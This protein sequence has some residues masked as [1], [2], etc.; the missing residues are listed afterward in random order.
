M[1]AAQSRAHLRA[2]NK[3]DAWDVLPF[4]T[5]PTLVPQDALVPSANAPWQQDGR[6]GLFDEFAREAASVLT[7]FGG[8]P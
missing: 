8:T 7:S 2:S 6:H 4:I 1:S 3:H 5:A